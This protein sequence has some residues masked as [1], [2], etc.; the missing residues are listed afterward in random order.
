MLYSR[1]RIANNVYSADIQDALI[2]LPSDGTLRKERD[3][4]HALQA[5]SASELRK[6]LKTNPNQT[7]RAVFGID[8]EEGRVRQNCGRATREGIEG[9]S[10]VTLVYVLHDSEDMRMQ[11]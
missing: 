8:T 11:L 5:K 1:T 9:S 7:L 4:I 2:Q 6:W 10:L 3:E